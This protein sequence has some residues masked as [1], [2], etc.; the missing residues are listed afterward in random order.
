MVGKT[1]RGLRGLRGLGRE[2]GVSLFSIRVIRVI[3]GQ[4]SSRCAKLPGEE[5]DHRVGTAVIGSA[6]NNRGCVP[7][8]DIVRRIEA[9][10]KP[11]APATFS[12]VPRVRQFEFQRLKIG[13]EDYMK[14]EILACDLR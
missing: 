11:T 12:P 7:L 5:Q 10:I 2:T 14:Q 3:R 4:F 13:V 9:G 1:S 8:L 6:R